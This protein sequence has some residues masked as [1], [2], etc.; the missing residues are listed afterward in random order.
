MIVLGLQFGHDGSACVVAD[1]R[2]LSYVC[3]ERESRVKHA[4]G[5]TTHEVELALTRA[6]IDAAAIDCVGIV[7]TQNVEILSGL[8]EGFG[9]RFAR[10]PD[11]HA[12]SPYA[13]LLE[14][15]G[16][17]VQDRLSFQLRDL[18]RNPDPKSFLYQF[19][20]A[21]CP[22]AEGIRTQ[23]IA[24]TGWLDQYV[25]MAPWDKGATLSEIAGFDAA[26]LL[27]QKE[28]KYGF[29]YPV[30][31]DF[32]GR[33]LP[34]YFVNHHVA[35]G[36]SCFFRSGFPDASILT[37]DGFSNGVG[38]HSGLIMYGRG[39]EIFAMGPH[40]LAIG[41]LYD[42]VAV[43]LGLGH[44]GPAGKLMG[45]APYGK[46]RFFRH[47][48]VGNWYDISRRFD[49][50]HAAAWWRHCTNLIGLMGYDASALAVKARITEPV[51]AD[52]AASTQKVFE[53]CY[54]QA[55]HGAHGLLLNSRIRTPRL[56]L[57]GGTALNCPS[58]SRI[59]REGPF[60]DV[61]VEPSCGDDGL[62]I[63]AALYVH[64]HLYGNPRGRCRAA[65]GP[66]VSRRAI[67]GGVRRGCAREARR[68][69][70]GRTRRERARARRAGP[71]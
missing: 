21:I 5:L 62:A 71:P 33:S 55:I 15:H 3:R 26:A 61:F 68:R 38:Y 66:G 32:R 37:H 6:G 11:D 49:A 40:H 14:R 48:F 25:S 42:R 46:P 20:S 47:D 63:G 12:P 13:D 59:F 1:G 2:V 53:E 23:T 39:N 10:H 30:S 35:H 70:A 22:E 56:C 27:E 24:S 36:S 8:I 64:H 69:P 19:Y 16:Q 41:G 44:V 43:A 7:S 18:F 34:G 9:I 67:P 17:K 31:V 45:L 65:R 52:L 54:L 58:N 4:I 29:H 60:D 50:A 57:S 28:A 51:N